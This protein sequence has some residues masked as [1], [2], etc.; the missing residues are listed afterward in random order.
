MILL[1]TDH[2]TVLKYPNTNRYALLTERMASSA[3]SD[4][5]T[6]IVNAE[7]QLRG[8]LAE[9]HRSRAIDKQVESYDHLLRLIVFF[10]RCRIVPFDHRAASQYQA[11]VK[12]KL[13]IGTCDLRIAAIAMATDALLFSANLSDF[14]KVPGLRV[15]SWLA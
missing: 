11:L 9:I 10:R 12:R 4:F 2:L 7:E 1:D 6:T 3:D 15:E 14:R 13:R 5:A 8:W